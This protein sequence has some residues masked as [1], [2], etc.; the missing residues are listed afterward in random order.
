MLACCIA[1]L[2]PIGLL[3][4]VLDFGATVTSN[5]SPYATGS[6]CLSITVAWIM[7]TWYGGIGLGSGDI[8]LAGDSA[9]PSTEG[10]QQPPTFSP[11]PIVAKRLD[12]SGYHLVRK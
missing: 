9:P 12:G 10:A 11:I 8:V 4:T 1:P 5:G 7:P 6:V 2:R 3:T